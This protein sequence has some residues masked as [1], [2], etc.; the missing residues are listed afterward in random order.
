MEHQLRRQ[1]IIFDVA[2][3]KKGLMQSATEEKLPSS[4]PSKNLISNPILK[5]WGLWSIMYFI[6]HFLLVVAFLALELEGLL[7][8]VPVGFFLERFGNAEVGYV[9]A[10]WGADKDNEFVCG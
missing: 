6:Y 7:L 8:C 1:G 3:I 4:F 5:K 10:F 2:N 9:L